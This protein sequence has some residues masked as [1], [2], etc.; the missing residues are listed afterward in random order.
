[1]ICLTKCNVL[2]CLAIWHKHFVCI[3]LLID[4]CLPINVIWFDIFAMVEYYELLRVTNS[5]LKFICKICSTISSNIK[6]WRELSISTCAPSSA[7]AIS[8]L[9]LPRTRSMANVERTVRQK[10]FETTFCI[11]HN[12]C[13]HCSVLTSSETLC[14][15]CMKLLAF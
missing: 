3:Y 9:L 15:N 5:F 2:H 7:L 10:S 1:M 8:M 4:P 11:E 14:F 13:A 12:T 6:K